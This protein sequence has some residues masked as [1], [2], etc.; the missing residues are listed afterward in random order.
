MKKI[1]IKGKKVLSLALG[2]TLIV[3]SAAA[4]ARAQVIPDTTLPN[5]SVVTPGGNGFQIDGGTTAGTNLFH[6]LREFSLPTGTEAFFNNA[7]T[8]DNIITR[9]TGG[10]IS[11]IDGLIRANGTAN[12]FLLNPNG[13]IF[14]PNARLDIGGSFFGSTADSLLFSDGSSFSATNTTSKPLLTINVP[15][16]L[17]LGP[18]PGKIRVEGDGHGYSTPFSVPVDR[19]EAS[20]G[21]E[22]TPD[23]TL[24]LVGGDIEIAGGVLR[25]ESGR[26]ELASTQNGVVGLG[27]NP[28]P[29]VPMLQVDRIEELLDIRLSQ[30]AGVD[31]SGT[32]GGSIHLVAGNVTLQDGSMALIVNLG[33]TP[34]GDIIVSARDSV[35]LLG[36]NASATVRSG[37]YNESAARGDSGKIDIQTTS[38]TAIDGGRIRSNS[39]DSGDGGTVEIDARESVLFVGVTPTSPRFISGIGTTGFGEGDT[40]NITITT[41]RL[42]LMDGALINASVVGG[43][44]GNGRRIEVNARESIELT[45]FFP[46]RARP[47][48]IDSSTLG[49]GNGGEIV[50]NTPR[51]T[52]LD[53]GR[54]TSTTVA[55]GKG[56]SAIVN[57]SGLVEIVGQGDLLP[58][59][60]ASEGFNAN[61]LPPGILP[62]EPPP[63]IASGDSGAVILNTPQ[64][65]I[66]E[67]GQISV[68]NGGVGKGGDITLNTGSILLLDTTA[69]ITAATASGN[70][71]NISIATD[72]LQL[73]SASQI[74]TKADGNGNGGNMT[75][76]TNTI[77]ALGDSDITAN[78]QLGAGGNISITTRGIFLSGDSDITASSTLGIDGTVE[79][80][81]PE[82]DSTQGLV[83]LPQNPIKPR[84]RIV[85]GCRPGNNTLHVTG[86]G[87]LAEDPGAVI[88]GTT[89][90][91]DNN[92][93]R[94]QQ[95]PTASRPVAQ[96]SPPTP[97]PLVEATGWI[98]HPDG[99]IELVA[100]MP[101]A[102]GGFK[103]VSCQ[104]LSSAD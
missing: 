44:T 73:R 49:S 21:L 43:S 61:T 63:P 60:I 90:W 54:V 97:P 30:E 40:G 46:G 35:D 24:V 80:N 39:F 27:I 36:T 67:G 9:V 72:S 29:R 48:A 33:D 6:S 23:R 79:I 83:E 51:L 66:S 7:A 87:G 102:I 65:R 14:G 10:E 77:V 4:T 15:M 75:I 78:A 50:L 71:G 5:N 89:L 103:P 18:T 86:R 81:N 38:L 104:D 8:I 100:Q 56:G 92:D 26:I 41:G 96:A 12:L 95:S 1:W 99:T 64:L 85:R 22:V 58:S 55:G 101:G 42:Q 25:A 62:G 59:G 91:R 45:G 76:N 34:S 94:T 69:G 37:L 47:S 57:A 53:G 2:S 82:V 19:T 11:N 31:V 52:L 20:M 13:I 98:K 16:G 3:S 88:R 32:P 68:A 28:S 93:Y 17:Q 74:S 84:D 70:G